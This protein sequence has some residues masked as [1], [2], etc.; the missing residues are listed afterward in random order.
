[1]KS[2]SHFGENDG[3][4]PGCGGKD[5]A[6]RRG[7]LETGVAPHFAGGSRRARPAGPTAPAQSGGHFQKLLQPSQQLLK[8]LP[9][10]AFLKSPQQLAPT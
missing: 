4:G 7:A 6:C 1:M 2:T 3:D 5:D 9:M 8:L 10:G